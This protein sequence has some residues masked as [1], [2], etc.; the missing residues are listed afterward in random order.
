MNSRELLKKAEGMNYR[1]LFHSEEHKESFFNNPKSF[2]M[3]VGN[4]LLFIEVEGEIS[5]YWAGNTLEE[6]AA[7]F[8]KL[9]DKFSKGTV[10]K[11]HSGE[12]KKTEGHAKE[13]VDCFT[14][15]GCNLE[16]H[17]MGIVTKNL[18]GSKADTT[19]VV[20]ASNGDKEGIFRV[21]NTSLDGEQF[22]MDDEE[23]NDYISKDN[24]MVFVIKQV[25]DVAGLLFAKVYNNRD[26]KRVFI[27]GLAV[28][29]KYRGKGFSN[30][31][32]YKAFKWAE[33][34]GAVDSM[35]WVEKSNDVAIRL[36]EKF[37]YSPYGDEEVVFKYIV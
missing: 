3:E 22:G 27:R 9:R 25:S 11:I 1:F 4:A 36:Y 21:I 30:M 33:E 19:K 6:V 37:G 18:I 20:V 29:E 10:I 26:K 34:K 2:G 24:N 15:V 8:S 13:T 35:L 12:E 23:Y 7:A 5:V 31:L 14:K 28:D 16:T 17:R 32:L